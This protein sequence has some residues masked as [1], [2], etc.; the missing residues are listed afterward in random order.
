MRLSGSVQGI[1]LTLN[2]GGYGIGRAIADAFAAAGAARIAISGRT[3]SKLKSSTAELKQAFPNT[4]FSYFVADITDAKAVKAMFESFG[5]PDVLVNNAGFLPSPANFKTV[6]LKEWWEGFEINVLGTA[7]VTQEFLRAKPDGK[8][9]VVITVNTIGAHLGTQVPRLS[10]YSASKAGS[11]RMIESIQAETPDVRFVSV[12]PGGVATDMLVKS[13]LDGVGELTDADLAA[14]FML[15]LT[16][17]EAEFMKGRF[18]WVNWDIDELKAKKDEI[19]EKDLL[20]YTLG[21][22]GYGYGF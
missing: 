11:L 3:E 14:N 8:E 1:R 17:P 9:A 4:E 12:H 22:F 20:K 19:L 16:S 18:A 21:G 6:D 15:W 7:I 2:R 13:E 10:S 5:A